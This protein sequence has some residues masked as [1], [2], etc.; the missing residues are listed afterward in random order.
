MFPVFK[1]LFILIAYLFT[2]GI[3]LAFIIPVSLYFFP[4]KKHK[5]VFSRFLFAYM[6][7]AVN[8]GLPFFQIL[9]IKEFIGAEKVGKSGII[10]SN[11]QSFLDGFLVMGHF[12]SV[13]LIKSSYKFNPLFAWISLLFDFIP[14][15]FTAQGLIS[16]DR[17]LRKRLNE[18]ERIYICP[19]GTRSKNGKIG[20]F[21]SLAF[22]IAGDLQVPIYPIIIQYSKPILGKSRQSFAFGEK[23][24]IKIRVLD[25]IYPAENE[26]TA[27][28]LKR[29]HELFVSAVE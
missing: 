2:G 8:S 6:K 17:N 5:K 29:T 12:P 27:K 28:L 4:L 25:E 11:H 18:D 14:L 26:N 22:K 7:W 15:K 3:Y 21:N 13:P 1:S 24:E 23:V 20:K 19:E 9:E 10:I 16:A